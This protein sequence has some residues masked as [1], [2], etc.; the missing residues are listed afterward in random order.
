MLLLRWVN[1]VRKELRALITG[2]LLLG[3]LGLYQ[4]ITSR[5]VP[6]WVY[7]IVTLLF[8]GWAFF[9]AWARQ[10]NETE[11]ALQKVRDVEKKIYDGRPIFVLEIRRQSNENW[12]FYLK[13]CGQRTA[14]YIKLQT[15]RSNQKKYRLNFTEISASG[16]GEEFSTYYYV[17]DSPVQNLQMLHKFLNDNEVHKDPLY[18]AAFEWFD[19]PIEFRDMDESI[20]QQLV[21]FC[22]DV[23]TKSLRAAGV[24][25]T[26]K[27][28]DPPKQP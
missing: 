9:G 28:L 27:Q 3:A 19:V 23:E 12:I 25:Y 1:E 6:W 5:P 13:N 11:T 16:P 15:V 22:F 26:A 10:F 7:I 8:L 14:R 17:D 21:R 2:S 20:C 18:N 4:A 24:P